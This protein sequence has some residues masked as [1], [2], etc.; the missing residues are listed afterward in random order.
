MALWRGAQFHSLSNIAAIFL[1]GTLTGKQL[2]AF[3]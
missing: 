2:K 1:E 3:C